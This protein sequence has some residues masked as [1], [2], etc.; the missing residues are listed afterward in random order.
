MGRDNYHVGDLSE[1]NCRL[2]L[3]MWRY[4]ETEIC[5]CLYVVPRHF[6][7]F[8]ISYWLMTKSSVKLVVI[9]HVVSPY[10]TRRDSRQDAGFGHLISIRN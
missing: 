5:Q 2:S 3:Y 7:H 8:L 6:S 1:F 10:S 9:A 4:H